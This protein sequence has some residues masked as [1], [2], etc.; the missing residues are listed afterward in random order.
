MKLIG[1]DKK[2]KRPEFSGGDEDWNDTIVLQTLGDSP[3]ARVWQFLWEWQH[4]WNESF[5]NIAKGA[6]IS[7]N[8]LY[9]IW[10][11]FIDNEIIIPT[12]YVKGVQLYG[13]NKNSLLFKGM[14]MSR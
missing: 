8:S 5:S 13:T 7:R 2:T 11:Y 9:K 12:K 1:F 4:G 3:T 14:G 6:G 10:N